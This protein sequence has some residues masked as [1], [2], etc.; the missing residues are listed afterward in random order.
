MKTWKKRGNVSLY[1]LTKEEYHNTINVDI[2]TNGGSSMNDQVVIGS[3][4]KKI[5]GRI[6]KRANHKL[7]L[8][9]LTMMQ[10]QIIFFLWQRENKCASQKDLEEYLEV[11]HP[12]VVTILESMKNK[13]M[14]DCRFD[15][16]DKRMKMVYLTWGNNALYEEI[17]R[18]ASNIE[19]S[20]TRNFTDEEKSI[21]VQLLNR[22]YH[23]LD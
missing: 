6:E 18:D 16:D 1:A 22:A 17:R 4:L 10:M 23:N 7:K 2:Y 20:L 15:A 8:H 14:V 11:S 13:E 19:N 12:T 5:N 3:L 9:R 21:F